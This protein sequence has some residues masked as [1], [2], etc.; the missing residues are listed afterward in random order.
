MPND[1]FPII[2][3][4]GIKRPIKGPA[5]YQ[6]QGSLIKSMFYSVDGQTKAEIGREPSSLIAWKPP[7]ISTTFL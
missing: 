5:I 3:N 6:G 2:S 4:N 7:A 1:L